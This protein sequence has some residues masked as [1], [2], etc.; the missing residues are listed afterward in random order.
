MK[1]AD[2]V[3]VMVPDSPD[4]EEVLA[5]EGGVFE[6]AEPG[7]LIIDFSSIRP[8]VTAALAEQAREQGFRILDAPVSG[9]E[10]GA[11]NAAL[12]IMVGGEPADFAEAQP[13]LDAVGRRSSTSARVA[14]ARPSRRP[15]S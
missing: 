13:I 8:D 4:V 15:T 5:G 9:G 2:V 1:G 6:H 3:A 14:P 7:T 11:R 10:A 12:S